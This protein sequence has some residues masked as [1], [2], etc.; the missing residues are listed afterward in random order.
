VEFGYNRNIVTNLFIRLIFR[1]FDYTLI[2]L[3]YDEFHSYFGAL[4]H[5]CCSLNFFTV[6]M[7]PFK[8]KL[9]G[10]SPKKLQMNE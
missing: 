6:V 1:L 5:S 2:L 10:S 4:F 7:A 3:I 8:P 9:F